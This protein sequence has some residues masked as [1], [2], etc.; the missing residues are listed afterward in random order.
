MLT[1]ARTF[2]SVQSLELVA[3]IQCSECSRST[4][5]S[6]LQQEP[7]TGNGSGLELRISNAGHRHP[8]WHL[9]HLAKVLTPVNV[10]YFYS[11]LTIPQVSLFNKQVVLSV[12]FYKETDIE[13]HSKTTRSYGIP[14]RA[15][16]SHTLVEL[17]GPGMLTAIL[18]PYAP[19][20][21]VSYPPRCANCFLI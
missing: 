7:I 14:Q 6:A 19:V 12:S 5:H 20:L 2:N 3:R 21:Y 15:R 17:Q 10:T 13:T 16:D 1:D 4:C 9:T 18:G 8:E 11:E